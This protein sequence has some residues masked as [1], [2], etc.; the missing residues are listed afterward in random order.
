MILSAVGVV[1]ERDE[2]RI[3]PAL[4]RDPPPERIEGGAGA[5]VV[6]LVL[7]LVVLPLLVLVLVLVT[8]GRVGLGGR[9]TLC[10]VAVGGAVAAALTVAA[11]DICS[12]IVS[13]FISMYS[14]ALSTLF[15]VRAS[16]YS[17]HF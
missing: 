5:V 15:P 10:L 4:G 8:A 6:P 17:A 12:S 14:A 16:A 7:L 11:A 13:M 1:G 2:G 3:A 9:Y